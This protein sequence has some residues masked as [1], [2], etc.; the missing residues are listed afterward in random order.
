MNKDEKARLTIFKT[1][2][3]DEPN[4]SEILIVVK[5]DDN[6]KV[7]LTGTVDDIPYSIDPGDGSMCPICGDSFDSGVPLA[8]VD[9]ASM[10][11]TVEAVDNLKKLG[12]LGKKFRFDTTWDFRT[13]EETTAYLQG[14]DYGVAVIGNT[15]TFGDELL[16]QETMEVL[17]MLNLIDVPLVEWNWEI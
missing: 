12:V 8:Q 14:H 17:A 5:D 11:T 16:G 4:Y 9:F 6:K 7:D 2:W 3:N 10:E 15:I 1:L 13:L